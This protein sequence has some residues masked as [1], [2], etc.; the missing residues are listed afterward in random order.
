MKRGHGAT[1]L[2]AFLLRGCGDLTTRA[3]RRGWV[4]GGSRRVNRS[5][6]S[7]G[8]W[9]GMRVRAIATRRV[10]GLGGMD[11]TRCRGIHQVQS[12]ASRSGNQP[13]RPSP[14]TCNSRL[15]IFDFFGFCKKAR[16]TR[17]SWR[18][19]SSPWWPNFVGQEFDRLDFYSVHWIFACARPDG[20]RSCSRRSA[21]TV[22]YLH[23]G[24]SIFA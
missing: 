21:S 2:R 13:R 16:L 14:S 22:S 7:S 6:G 8:L 12:S 23:R 24:K 19:S 9:G 3:I 18:A 1:P 5:W 17:G 10:C 15:G 20:L 4:R 11:S